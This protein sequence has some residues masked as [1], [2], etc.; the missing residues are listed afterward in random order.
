[1]SPDDEELDEDEELEE[2]EPVEVELRRRLRVDLVLRRDDVF[3]FFTRVRRRGPFSAL[4]SFEP[5]WSPIYSRRINSA[6]YH[7]NDV[8]LNLKRF[9]AAAAEPMRAY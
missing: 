1:M 9:T 4:R 5:S 6:R 8:F 7:G 2:D 3:F